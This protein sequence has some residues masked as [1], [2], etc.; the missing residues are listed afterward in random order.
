MVFM[1]KKTILVFIDWYIPGYKAGGPIKSVHSMVKFLKDEFN[2]LIITSNTDFND[3]APYSTVKS[4]QWTQTDGALV[5]YASSEFLN[6]RNL[7]KLLATIQYDAIYLNSL[8]SIYFSLYPLLFHKIGIIRKP[9][10]LAPR[11]MLGE[12]A[13]KLKWKKKKLFLLFFKLIQSH[14]G[15]TWHATS[16]QERNECFKIFG[17][18]IQVSVV[19]N[20]QYNDKKNIGSAP[21]KK[22]GSLK[23]FFL[24]RI[25]EKKNILFALKVLLKISLL[26]RQQLVFDIYGPIENE[27]YWRECM[28]LIKKMNE[29]GHSVEYKGAVKSEDVQTVIENYHFL[30]L[31]TLNENYGHVIVESLMV[32]RPV[33]ISDQTPWTQLEN[34]NVGWDINLNNSAKFESV[35]QECLLMSD[36]HYKKMIDDSKRY[37]KEFCNSEHNAGLMKRM[38]ENLFT[39]V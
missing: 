13:L 36:E 31:P 2:F 5:F 33:I 19:P 26:P 23:L 32:G 37:A 16:E 6:K 8:F 3:A 12:G 24:S 11:G 25:S 27:E 29:K 17:T 4:D 10:M 22:K 21:E 28:V 7:R 38:F 30:F 1:N 14:K 39:H 34:Q 35:I 15:I 20:L 18:D 9:L